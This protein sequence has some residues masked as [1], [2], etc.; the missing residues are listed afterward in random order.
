MEIYAYIYISRGRL[1]VFKYIYIY[2]Y[3]YVYIYISLS[4]SV[5]IHTY[6]EREGEGE[7]AWPKRIPGP[8][9]AGRKALPWD[10]SRTSPKYR[11]SQARCMPDSCS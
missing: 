9:P 10:V 3:L 2:M 7:L 5:Y 6:M 4:L 8:I 11:E 1:Y